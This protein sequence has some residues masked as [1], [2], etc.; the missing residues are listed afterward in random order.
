MVTGYL[1]SRS[2][3]VGER[4]I[5]RSLAKVVPEYHNQRKNRAEQQTN[6]VPYSAEYF[7][8]KLHVDQNEKLVMY[9]VVHVCAIERFHSFLRE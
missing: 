9:G 8:H 7:G 4:R 2:L 5:G 3:N 6:P 1:R